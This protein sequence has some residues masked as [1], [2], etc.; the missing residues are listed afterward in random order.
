MHGSAENGKVE[1][2]AGHVEASI[3]AQTTVFEAEFLGKGKPSRAQ[4][5]L[6]QEID[7]NAWRSIVRH[8][9]TPVHI[10]FFPIIFWASMSMGS[11]ANALLAVNILQSPGLSAPP[12]NFT[13]TQV[14]YANFALVGGGVIGLAV[15]G[16]WSDHISQKATDKNKGVREPEMRLVSLIPFALAAAVGLVVSYSSSYPMNVLMKGTN[17]RAPKGFWRWPPR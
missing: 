15:A 14:G 12:Y 11:A 3:P 2:V 8:F 5:G 10:L 1:P 16:P 7:R 6:L 4:F 13:P 17:F 9:L